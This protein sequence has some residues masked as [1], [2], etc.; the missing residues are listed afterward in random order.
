MEPLHCY[1][2]FLFLINATSVSRLQSNDA[3]SNL[4]GNILSYHRSGLNIFDFK[5]YVEII[6]CPKSMSY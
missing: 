4:A 2:L 3:L 5:I 1:I 6:F